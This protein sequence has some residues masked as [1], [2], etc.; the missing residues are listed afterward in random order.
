[1]VYREYNCHLGYILG[2]LL[3]ICRGWNP[4]QV[5][6]W[7]IWIHYKGPV[8]LNNQDWMESIRG[9]FFVAQ[10]FWRSSCFVRNELPGNYL[11]PFMLGRY[12]NID[13][14]IVRFTFYHEG[15]S[16]LVKTTC[17][18]GSH[19]ISGLLIAMVELVH[20]WDSLLPASMADRWRPL[21]DHREKKGSLVGL[22]GKC[23][24]WNTTQ[25]CGGLWLNHL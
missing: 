2:C 10:L 4:T 1:M 17:R 16:C 25:F 24:G 20:S 9:R 12:R 18:M 15:Q 21:G 5:L 14:Q 11:C 23:R 3:G 13:L 19:D 7:K 6:W 22:L 8:S